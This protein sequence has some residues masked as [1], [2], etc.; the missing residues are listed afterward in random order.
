MFHGMAVALMSPQSSRRGGPTHC[1]RSNQNTELRMNLK[2]T[3]LAAGVAAALAMGAS[4]PASAYVYGTGGLSIDGL[5]IGIT[6]FSN[7]TITGFNFT[8]TDTSTLNGSTIAK[9][10]SCSG[11]P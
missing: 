1:C 8:Q 9:G 3:A 7:A 4:A 10:A 6:P 5:T 2:R 11:T